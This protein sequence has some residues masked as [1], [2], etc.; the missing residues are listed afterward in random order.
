[1][2]DETTNVAKTRAKPGVEVEVDSE[3][4]RL[5]K[6]GNT[7]AM[8]KYMALVY[9]RNSLWGLMWFELRMLFLSNL[10]GA[11]GI[12]LRKIFYK[13]LFHTMEGGEVIGRGVTLRYP[14]R[15]RLGRGT[16]IDDNV[17]LD[18][19]GDREVTIDIGQDCMIGRNAVLSCKQVAETSGRI[20]L[21]DRVNISVNCTLISES[22]MEIGEKVLIAGHCY[23][24]AGGNHGID[25]LDI[26]ILDQPMVHRGGI[27]VGD[28][29]WLGAS[30]V[31]LDG[32]HVGSGAV[33]AAGAVVSDPVEPMTI[34]GGVPAKLLRRRE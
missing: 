1:M 25:R 34:V 20:V 30:T 9:G 6:D 33:V 10:P 26:A 14:H 23:L 22:E 27:R 7:S 8:K 28:G 29:A 18:G 2:T 32:A 16:I 19:K 17:V 5:M 31:I 13:G 24:N 11:L 15:I 12:A 21:K 3:I 4:R